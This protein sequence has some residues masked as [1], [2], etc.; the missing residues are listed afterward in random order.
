MI[1]QRI[2]WV[3]LYKWRHYINTVLSLRFRYDNIG[4]ELTGK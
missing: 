2:R 3:L 4:V 1:C